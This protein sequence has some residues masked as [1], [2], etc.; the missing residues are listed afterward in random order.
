MPKDIKQLNKNFEG[1]PQE[2]I[3]A[4]IKSNTTRKKFIVNEILKRKAGVIGIF[5]LSM[6]NGSDNWRNSAMLD[7]IKLLES[8]SQK[9]IIFEPMLSKKSFMG[10]ELEND[11]DQFKYKSDLIV[12]NR[13]Y[14]EISDCNKLLFTRDIFNDS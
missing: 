1:V 14:P 5:R 4:T 11:L 7:V 3:Q 8:K 6:K 12:A 9:I 13:I 10:I 2:L